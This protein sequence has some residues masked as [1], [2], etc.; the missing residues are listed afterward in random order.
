MS[1]NG[2][3]SG[4]FERISAQ[5]DEM[6]GVAKLL[7]ETFSV[8]PPEPRHLDVHAAAEELDRRARVVEEGERVGLL[9]APDG[10]DGRE[11]PRVALD[12]HVV[13][14]RDEHR[15]SEVRAVGELVEDA[16]ERLLRRREAH[17]DHVE[18]LLDRVAEAAEEDCA[19]AREA[20]A[21]DADARDRRL[22]ARAGARCRRT[23][24]RDRRRRPRC[25]PRRSI[26][27]S[28]P[29]EMTTALSSSP[30]SG[31]VASTPESRMQTRT[32]SP[33]APPSAHSRV[34]RSGQCGRERDPVD[35]VLR[36]APR[37]QRGLA[38]VPAVRGDVL[39]GT[40]LY[41]AR[42]AESVPAQLV[43]SDARGSRRG[44]GGRARSLRRERLLE[45]GEERVAEREVG[46]GPR[47]DLVERAA[48]ARKL[49][50]GPHPT[51]GRGRRSRRSTPSRSSS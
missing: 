37:G 8:R 31:W 30:T 21:E 38:R 18:A 40:G 43:R 17:V 7:P 34:T 20:R 42:P 35:R 26:S 1:W 47:D 33:V 16:R 32:P 45:V 11:A 51:A 50:R 15:A 25:P 12:R 4:C 36:E 22:R 49:L 46:L 2:V 10:D 29:I 13:R 48:C 9:V 19:A 39:H 27:S 24:C 5:I 44:C 23:P 3:S 41:G 14:R 28:S 6:C